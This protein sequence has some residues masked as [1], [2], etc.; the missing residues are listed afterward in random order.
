MNLNFSVGT[1]FMLHGSEENLF[2]SWRHCQT[3]PCGRAL[4]TVPNLGSFFCI[5]EPLALLQTS[6]RSL[7]IFT[8]KKDPS[9]KKQYFCQSRQHVSHLRNHVKQR[10][11]LSQHV[12]GFQKNNEKQFF[13]PREVSAAT[14]ILTMPRCGVAHARAFQRPG[15]L[16]NI[17]NF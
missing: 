13:W 15:V 3:P 6:Q 11:V 9:D 4:L 1:F 5:N 7:D 17:S 16:W 12:V 10:I 8:F 14:H 2:P